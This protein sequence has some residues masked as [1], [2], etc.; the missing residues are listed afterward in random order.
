[1]HTN[2]KLSAYLKSTGLLLN[3]KLEKLQIEL[4]YE[5]LTMGRGLANDVCINIRT[6]SDHHA[7]ISFEKDHWFIKDINS[8]N[9]ILVNQDKIQSSH[10]LKERDTVSIGGVE[11]YFCLNKPQVLPHQD[12]ISLKREKQQLN[13][14]KKLQDSNQPLY[15]D[16]ADLTPDLRQ[17]PYQ[18]IIVILLFSTLTGIIFFK[19]GG[20]LNDFLF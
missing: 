17:T 10:E 7:Q 6:V 18:K 16:N 2:S 12:S 4:P 19:F 14:G 13:P 15:S 9:G 5:N 3:D 8:K 1:M 11:F 20:K